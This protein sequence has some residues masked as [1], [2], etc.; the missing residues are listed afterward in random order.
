[1]SLS[2]RRRS[3][4][5]RRPPLNWPAPASRRSRRSLPPSRFRRS[6]SGRRNDGRRLLFAPKAAQTGGRRLSRAAR[7]RRRARA[8]T[9]VV[10]HAGTVRSR[11]EPR[12]DRLTASR[13]ARR[14][15]RVQ[16]ISPRS[17]GARA[18]KPGERAGGRDDDRRN[19]RNPG[20]GAPPPR[21]ERLPIPIRLSPSSPRSRRSSKRRGRADPF[22]RLSGP[23][24]DQDFLHCTLARAAAYDLVCAQSNVGATSGAGRNV[25]RLASFDLFIGAPA[26]STGRSDSSVRRSRVRDSEAARAQGH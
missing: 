11:T 14:A 13:K 22:L 20:V 1:M 2:P 26:E 4:Q 10:P 16:T 23:R 5:R 17:S 24:E 21:R 12:M 18:G 6:K 15:S 25:R 7:Q 9:G 19:Q 8:K 3:L